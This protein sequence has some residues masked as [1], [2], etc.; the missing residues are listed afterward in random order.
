MGLNRRQFLQAS[1]WGLAS[2]LVAPSAEPLAGPRTLRI[3]LLHLA[4]RPADLA[5]NRRL[6][7]HTLV[8]AA[9]WHAAWILTP[10]LSITGYTF[11]CE[12]SG[13][14]PIGSAEA[15]WHVDLGC[16][17]GGRLPESETILAISR[18]H[19]DLPPDVLTEINLT[20][21]TVVTY[22]HCDPI[23]H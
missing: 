5:Y 15:A 21:G 22:Y 1:M 6:L 17:G 2:I 18:P 20:D 3:A 4:P 13:V 9:E 10:E 16:Q 19:R 12:I 8:T 23:L 14:E 11:V 7:E